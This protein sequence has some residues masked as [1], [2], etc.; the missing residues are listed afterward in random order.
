MKPLAPGF[1]FA[2]E[3]FFIVAIWAKA[4]DA[5]GFGGA[6]LRIELQHSDFGSVGCVADLVVGDDWRASPTHDYVRMNMPD[7]GIVCFVCRNESAYDEPPVLHLVA[8]IV[9]SKGGVVG[10]DTDP[11]QGILRREHDLTAGG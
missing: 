8:A 6:I 9:E 11:S 1:H 5:G 10:R 4:E 7:H 3:Y 2:A